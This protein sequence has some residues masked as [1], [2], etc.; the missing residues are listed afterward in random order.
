MPTRKVRNR[1]GNIIGAFPSLKN[2][3]TVHY[4]S[5][6]E[7][8]LLFF[9]EFD[10][11]VLR[12]ELQP[13]V[14]TGPDSEGKQRSYTPDVLITRKSGRELIEC[15]PASRLED[16][17]TK[18]Q[19]ALG[20]TWCEANDCDY[21]VITDADL[22]V[23]SQLANLKLLWRYARMAPPLFIVEHI[24]QLLFQIPEGKS[25]SA[26][27][28]RLLDGGVSPT[29][30]ATIYHLIFHHILAADIHQA[31]SPQSLITLASPS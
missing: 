20:V 9:L 24:R 31:L 12:Y 1:E 19:I 6:I 30:V 3:H 29:P 22:R 23:G 18:R 15:K 13:M 25:L 5:T 4:E 21:I 11:T 26:L 7:R 2:G 17:H 28:Q 10:Q 14:I 27:A 16:D 8:D